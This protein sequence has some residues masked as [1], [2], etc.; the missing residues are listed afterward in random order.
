MVWVLSLSALDLSTQR[1]TPE[2]I[3]QHS[4]FVWI[5]Q[6]VKP[7]HPISS[8]TSMTLDPEAAPKGISGSTS[9]LS[10]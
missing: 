5:W 3:L 7:P 2:Y 10:V 4:E 9:Y 1:L 8:S 6:A